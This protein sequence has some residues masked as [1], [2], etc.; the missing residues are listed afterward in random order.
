MSS[1][2]VGEQPIIIIRKSQEMYN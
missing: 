1:L 2:A